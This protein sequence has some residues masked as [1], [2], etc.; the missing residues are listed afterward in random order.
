MSNQSVRKKI[1][2]ILAS[3][4]SGTNLLRVL[5]GNHSEIHAPVAVH[6]FNIFN[7]IR[8]YYGDLE[9]NGNAEK[10]L[11]HFLLSA[12]HPYTKWELNATASD[13][14]KKYKINSFEKAFDA[15]YTEQAQMNKKMHYVIKDNDMF[16]FIHNTEKLNIS[17]NKVFYI[18]LHR[19]PRDHI[20]S[21][22]KTPLFLHTPFDIAQKWN[23]EQNQIMKSKSNIN[24]IDL[25][26]ED[27]ISHT[28]QEM[29]RVL[30][31]IGFKIDENCF[32]TDETNEE[33]K[34][35]EMWKNL[36][37]PIIRDNKK[38]YLKSLNKKELKIIETI[39][40]ENMKKLGYEFETEA[41]WKDYFK[42]YE[43]VILPRIREKSRTE[44]KLFFNEKMGDLSSKLEL[45]EKIRNDAKN[46]S[47]N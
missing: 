27:L 29:T 16:N 23:K 3:E 28:S 42:L 40:F 39:C 34:R 5:L 26:Y 11:E 38:K 6:F 47:K 20:V 24:Y 44:N 19:D 2:V 7:N 25:K 14:V 41:N 8:H 43:K 31:F 18:H 22:L 37:V 17:Q 36:S 21:W 32:Q 33:S 9:N 45:L 30:N 4:R 1:I 15:I 10:L 35:N 13:I 12:N 46:H